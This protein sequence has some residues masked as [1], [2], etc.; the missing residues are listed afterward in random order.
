MKNE[1]IQKAYE[2]AKER[3]AA[4]GV[5][6]EKVLEDLQQIAIS[7]HCWQADDVTGFENLGNLGGGGIQAT[8][9]YPGK[10]RNMEEIRQ[11]IEKVLTLVAGSHRLNL[12]AIY[13][14]F[15]GEIV[16]R[17]ALEPAHFA[18]WMQWAKE[19][20][21]KLDFNSTS[22][23]HPKSGELTLANPDKSIRAFWIEHTKR[24]RRISEAMGKF[25]NDPCIMN[26]WIHDG[27]KD[28]TVN[29]LKYRQLLEQSLD[30]IFAE[31]YKN[32]KDCIE[33]KLFGIGLESY[34]VGSY[35]FYL[36]YGAKKQ[37]MV[38]L[39][40]GHFHLSESIA[41]KISSLLLFTPEIMLHVS[42]PIRWDSDHVTI[43]NDDV[44]DLS[45]EIVRAGALDRVH[46]GLDYFDASINRLGA[47][48]I[49]IRATQKAFL[50]ALLE[51]IGRLR[52]YE[53][54]GRYFE[55]LALLEEA[56]SLPWNAV[57]DYFCLKNNI[58][59]GE[60]YI[61]DIQQYE[62]EVTSKR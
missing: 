1:L 7:I 2:I 56:K 35:D 15:G 16:D 41:D 12:H 37:K 42:R 51:P 11:D 40:T 36:G 31:E 38:T 32:M 43:L 18:G 34:T 62:K 8:G 46:I 57:W 49:G 4:V 44:L 45:K 13:G 25:Q 47:Y 53:A 30:E 23:G 10:A 39:D 26:L 28:F 24:C 19:K 33:A 17:D 27:S 3:Y 50:Q 59:V 61:A 60:E 14:D 22:F 5:D 52:E 20:G 58:P 48:V 55:R 29:R 54:G 6:A 21:L 9:N